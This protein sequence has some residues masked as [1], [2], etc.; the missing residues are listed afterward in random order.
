MTNSG[1][2]PAVRAVVAGHGD[3]AA[4]I[5]S[6]VA[7]I[8]GRAECFIVV[9]NRDRC[10]PDIEQVLRDAVVNQGVRVVFTDLPAGS[11]TMAAR[12]VI[13]DHPDVAL[14]TGANVAALLDFL[15][16]AGATTA[17]L[18]S[19]AAEKGREAIQCHGGSR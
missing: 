10:A 8:T 18:A 19:H 3:F 2:A 6:A 4:G 16:Q 17:S 12:K 9:T 13:R 7:Q 5:V 1:D 15:F 11:C 14:V